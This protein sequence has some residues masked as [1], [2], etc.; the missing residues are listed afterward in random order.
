MR[1][2]HGY[3]IHRFETQ[4]TRQFIVLGGVHIPYERGLLA[5]SDGDVVIHAICDALLGAC[6]LG[7]IGQHFPD[8]DLRYKDCDSR[9]LL[10]HVVDLVHL[11]HLSV[12]N[13]DVTI[14][15]QAPKLA[16]YTQAMR[17][18]LAQDLQVSLN[19][20]NI[21]ATTN[22]QLDALGQKLGIAVHAVALLKKGVAHENSG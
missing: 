7:D 16:P 17:E 15:A 19:A 8:T 11:A 21:K 14:I 13:V 4:P 6:A 18:N 20:I 3:D 10:C 22:E 2:G 9:T 5:H 1:I 12:A